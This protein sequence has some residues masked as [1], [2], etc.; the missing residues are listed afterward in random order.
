MDQRPKSV[1]NPEDYVCVA[2]DVTSLE[3]ATIAL[4]ELTN[5]NS[6]Q[7]R[8]TRVKVGN[9]LFWAKDVGPGKTAKLL[10]DFGLLESALLD[11][12]FGDTPGTMT[13]SVQGALDL[14]FQYF[15]VTSECGRPGLKE[16][17]A[18]CVA[19]GSGTPVAVTLLT[20][21]SE[22]DLPGLGF[23]AVK[24]VVDIVIDRV[25]FCMGAGITSFVCSPL[26]LGAI[27]GEGL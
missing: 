11:G 4:E 14:G 15:T 26:D 8:L 3:E 19:H 10:A 12:K 17:L 1:R 18:A 7:P 25:G 16:A 5:C 2:L 27:H 20:S 13:K 9:S 22:E 21:L 6:A 24:A 23:E